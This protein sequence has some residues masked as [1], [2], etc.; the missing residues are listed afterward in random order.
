MRNDALLRTLFLKNIRDQRR[1]LLGWSI[2][3]V[4][5]LA[6]MWSFY[7]TVRDQGE[8]MQKLL[9]SYPPQMQA[10]F[11][12]MSDFTTTAGYLRAELFSLTLPLLFI[13]YAIGRGADLIA[14]EE[15]RGDLEFLL[16][17]PVSRARVAVEKAAALAIVAAGLGALAWVVLYIGD[18]ALATD[19]GAARFAAACSMVVLLAWSFGALALSIGA[20]TGRKGIAVATASGAAVL[21]YLLDALSRLAPS[22]EAARYAS[23][24]YYYGAG[25]PLVNGFDLSAM[26]ILLALT[27]GIGVVGLVRFDRRDIGR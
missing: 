20:A 16:A 23:P 9:E 15:E 5:L 18:L 24:F 11:G 10:F 22:I 4:A 17:N 14:G 25:N 7:P 3:I 12:D 19:V 27:L 13:I 21:A 26:V 1:A 8:E 2:G 6:M